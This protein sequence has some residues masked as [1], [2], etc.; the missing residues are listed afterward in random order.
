MLSEN[1]LKQV[2]TFYHTYVCFLESIHFSTAKK[3][4]CRMNKSLKDGQKLRL[5]DKR[6]CPVSKPVQVINQEHEKEDK[7]ERLETKM[8][9]SFNTKTLIEKLP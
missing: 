7:K 8:Y 3:F 1:K 5:P 4:V 6:Q 9:I 2:N